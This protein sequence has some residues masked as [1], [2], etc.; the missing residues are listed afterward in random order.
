MSS[1]V[2]AMITYKCQCDI[3]DSIEKEKIRNNLSDEETKI[4]AQKM[5]YAL[6]LKYNT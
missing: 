5:I 2:E 4:I 1:I 6:Q 3:I